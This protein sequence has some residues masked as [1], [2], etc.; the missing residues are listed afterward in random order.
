MMH[1]NFSD[2]H[3]QRVQEIIGDRL[4]QHRIARRW[5]QTE[6]ADRVKVSRETLSKVE[7]GH[8]VTLENFLR[9]LKGLE[10]IDRL[11]NAIDDAGDRPTEKFKSAGKRRYR[12]RKG[13][14]TGLEVQPGDFVWPEDRK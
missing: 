3:T 7:N 13:A 14:K 6:L 10:L 4:R 1:D 12:V 11:D 5:Q 8:S 9:V 2:M